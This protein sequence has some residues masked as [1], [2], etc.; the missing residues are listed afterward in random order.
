VTPPSYRFDLTLEEDFIEEIVRLYGYER[1]PATPAAH[2][3]RMLASAEARRT[4]TALKTRLAARDWQEVITFTFVSSITEALLAP[5]AAKNGA[6]IRVLNPIAANV[7][8]LRTTMLPGL[9]ETLRTNVSRKAPRVRIFEIGRVFR[10]ADPGYAQPIRVGGLAYGDAIREQWGSPTR[11]VDMFDIKADV[12]ALAAPRRV[13]TAPDSL[14]WLHPAR[15]ARVLIDGVAC[16]FLGELH[17][18]LLPHFELAFSP[19]VFELDLEPLLEVSLP[20]ATPISKFPPVRRD[21]AIVV[22]EGVSAQAI[23]DTVDAVKPPYVERIEPFDLYHG[24]RLPSGKKSLAILVLMQDTSRT[25]TDADIDATEAL[26][27]AVARDQF[28]ATLRQQE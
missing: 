6:A 3:Q 23:L 28:A 10:H 4:P 21:I 13:T 7:D 17:P 16:G 15:S 24:A 27:L 20:A 8:V 19:V 2:V 12:E 25:L 14:P 5:N 11:R 1:I 22:D 26:L 9:L 18:R